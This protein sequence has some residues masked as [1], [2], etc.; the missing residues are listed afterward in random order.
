[1]PEIINDDL[2]YKTLRYSYTTKTAS[3]LKN[4][5]DYLN[6][7][8]V[9]PHIGIKHSTYKVFL[10]IIKEKGFDRKKTR[11]I[12]QERKE[13][14][15][16]KCGS[17][18]HGFKIDINK[19]KKQTELILKILDERPSPDVTI[20]HHPLIPTHTI[21]RA[22]TIYE[23]DT[24]FD[25]KII[26]V[27]DFDSTALAVAIIAKPKEILLVDIDDRLISFFQKIAKRYNL[28]LRTLKHDLK[29][30]LPK[31]LM[32]S[33]DIFIT[34]PPYA[35]MGMNT[36]ISRGISALKD[37]GIGFIA[38]PFHDNLP[39]SAEVLFEV[40][41]VIINA[42]CICTDILKNFHEY[43]TA[44]GLTSSLIRIQK[45]NRKDKI[46]KKSFYW[47]RK[48]GNKKNKPEVVI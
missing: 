2:L 10:D 1:M 11:S 24:L 22:A 29:K 21:L 42:D 45:G 23:L 46:D 30:P 44:D 17:C 27:G 3:N 28:P 43:Q 12:L 9:S 38:T 4:I 33:Y 18:N 47:W 48:E 41:K 19:F 40:Q 37:G 13:D 31:K 16:F 25:K 35:V 26:C 8:K 36:F 14:K 20:D 32:D 5:N 34:D 39:W 15:N 6:Q 7:R